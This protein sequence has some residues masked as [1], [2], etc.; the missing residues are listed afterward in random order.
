M[1]T[2]RMPRVQTLPPRSVQARAFTPRATVQA[3]AFHTSSQYHTVLGLQRA[4]QDSTQDMAPVPLDMAPVP[5]DS[6]QDMALCPCTPAPP[7]GLALGS[8]GSAARTVQ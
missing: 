7:A 6:T 5:Q 3:R 2:L 1:P 8:H 4:P